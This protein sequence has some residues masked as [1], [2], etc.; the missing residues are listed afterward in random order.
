MES[1]RKNNFKFANALFIDKE[2]VF[3]LL[4]CQEGLL[5]PVYHLM[6]FNEM[7]EVDKT[8]IFQGQSFPFS[9]VLAPS[10]KRNTQVIQNVSKGDVLTLVCEGAACGELIV[11]STFKIDRKERLL[12]IMSGD[13]Y[14]QKAQDIYKRIGDYAICG[15]YRLF[16]NPD[17]FS[18]ML[19]KQ[20]I[21]RTKKNIQAQHITAMALDASPITRIHERIFRFVLEESDLLVLPS[22]SAL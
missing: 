1:Q 21:L 16:L 10:G 12:K 14:S 5:A 18:F 22:L 15:E 13:I 4:L 2:A 20:T 8:G 19:N 9:F 7:Q 11:D 17:K 3:A 6:N